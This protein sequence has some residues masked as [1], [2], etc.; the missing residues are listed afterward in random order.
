MSNPRYGWVR[1]DRLIVRAPVDSSTSAIS[2]GDFLTLAT[3]GYVK[4][5]SAGDKVYG[6]AVGGVA[7]PA[8]DGAAT[9][10]VDIST[11]A[12]YRYPVDTGSVSVGDLFKTGDCGGAQKIDR[13]SP[14]NNDIFIVEVD[15]AAN[16][17]CITLKPSPTA[18]S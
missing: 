10:A 13:T 3:A 18:L 16:E 6:I 11:A 14:S 12:V 5:A 9:I 2:D 15:T 4:Q 1:G 17:Y 7:A 8:T